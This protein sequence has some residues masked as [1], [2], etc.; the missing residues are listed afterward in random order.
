MP[1]SRDAL[2]RHVVFPPD[3]PT[4]ECDEW[5]APLHQFHDR[6]QHH[7]LAVFFDVDDFMLMGGWRRSGHPLLI[8]CKHRVTRRYLN[9]D[10]AGNVWRYAAPRTNSDRTPGTY[11][12]LAGVDEALERLGLD[13][14][15]WMDPGRFGHL[16]GEDPWR[17][18][19][20]MTLDDTW[21]G[22]SC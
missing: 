20:A 22:G 18:I 9:V 12:R 4:G 2:S 5:C 3:N 11:R 7:P 8:L 1:K 21:G 14:M 13:E 16:K 19:D 15:P 10:V 6:I 17:E